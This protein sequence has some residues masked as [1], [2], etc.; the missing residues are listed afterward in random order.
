MNKA[1]L[2]PLFQ[3]LIVACW[4]GILPGELHAQS[5]STEAQIE[6]S[7]SLLDQGQSIENRVIDL[8]DILFEFDSPELTSKT[9]PYLD[10]VVTLMQRV[11]NIKVEISGH[12]DN[13]GDTK[14][15]LQLSQK[16]SN[17]VKKYLLAAGIDSSRIHAQGYGDTQP[18][19]ANDSQLGRAQNRRVEMK[20][21]KPQAVKTIQDII[22]LVSGDT[23][24]GKVL[25][26][27]ADGV[28]YR[29]FRQD[30][31]IVL[32]PEQVKKIIFAS[33]ETWF[34]PKPKQESVARR[35]PSGAGFNTFFKEVNKVLF[36]APD[37]FQKGVSVWSVHAEL[38]N[39]I[40]NGRP[41]DST[42]FI[43]PL[44]LSY[45]R[46]LWRNFGIGLNLGIAH[47]GDSLADVKYGYYSVGARW[48]Y[49]PNIHPKLD[50]YVGG[51]LS[52]RLIRL[53]QPEYKD[54]YYQGNS[55]DWFFGVRYFPTKRLAFFGEIGSD[56]I[57]QYNLGLSLVLGSPREHDE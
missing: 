56:A 10:K 18:L 36:T 2:S 40:I 51:A 15:N 42:N 55:Y 53:D 21:I 54:L 43:P 27:E 22:I 34:P 16:R 26:A 19:V 3:A 48:T 30:R 14:Y 49:H 25:M 20:I 45:E 35:K 50:P 5:S 33:G 23:I 38:R 29:S 1:K 6:E 39:N 9:K 57:S 11:P 37:Y 28:K 24:G 41:Y 13:I 12:T 52:Y 32:K 31:E 17:S 8:R 4:I 44:S 7:L 46:P 47:W